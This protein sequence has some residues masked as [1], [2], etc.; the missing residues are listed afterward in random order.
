MLT[1]LSR[2]AFNGRDEQIIAYRNFLSQSSPWLLLLTGMP[3]CGKSFFLKR[4]RELLLNTAL[5]LSL[6]FADTSLQTDPLALLSELSWQ[7]AQQCDTSSV[8]AFHAE[9]EK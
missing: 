2:S 6:D 7:C 1:S 8:E 5:M 3:G 9:L 4:M